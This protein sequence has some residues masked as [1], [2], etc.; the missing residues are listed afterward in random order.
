MSINTKEQARQH[1]YSVIEKF[2]DRN[3]EVSEWAVDTDDLEND[4]MEYLY[5]IHVV[6]DD[7]KFQSIREELMD[8]DWDGD[9]DELNREAEDIF[10]ER[11]GYS[12]EG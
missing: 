3:N 10:E 1:L 7:D 9:E 12:Y 11:Y 6:S 4:L 5:D 2:L 8:D